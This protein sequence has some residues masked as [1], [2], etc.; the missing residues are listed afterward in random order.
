MEA[1]SPVITI[2]PLRKFF[3]YYRE[4]QNTAGDRWKSITDRYLGGK[5]VTIVWTMRWVVVGCV[6]VCACVCSW[7]SKMEWGFP[8]VTVHWHSWRHVRY[9]ARGTGASSIFARNCLRRWLMECGRKTAATVSPLSRV[10]PSTR[11][12]HRPVPYSPP[13]T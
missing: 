13:P 3:I 1:V 7:L 5:Y 9:E 4:K 11:A 6:C 8:F 10:V 2:Y 12:H